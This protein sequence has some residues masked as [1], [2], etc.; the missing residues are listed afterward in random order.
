MHQFDDP[1]EQARRTPRLR[2]S[3][4]HSLSPRCREFCNGLQATAHRARRDR[5]QAGRRSR[6]PEIDREAAVRAIAGFRK[7]DR[8]SRPPSTQGLVMLCSGSSR[9]SGGLGMARSP[10]SCIPGPS[11]PD[12]NRS[13][14]SRDSQKSMTP[15]PSSIG[16]GGV[17]DQPPGR[18]T[19]RPGLRLTGSW[20]GSSL[21]GLRVSRLR[22][23]VG[24]AAVL[25]GCSLVGL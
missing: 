25:R 24:P 20:R 15:Q 13:K 16:P 6:L 18:E 17:E 3:N 12:T 7:G 19:A 14:A 23:V 9:T 8:R 21:A 4:H 11:L 10:S 2:T 5:A 22:T 1:R